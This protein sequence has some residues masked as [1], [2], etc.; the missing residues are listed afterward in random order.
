MD[1][2]LQNL[3]R[4]Y[5]SKFSL[6]ALHHTVMETLKANWANDTLIILGLPL[7]S[8]SQ[9]KISLADVVRES[10][11]KSS[12]GFRGMLST[13]FAFQF[14]YARAWFY[15]TDHWL[16]LSLTDP[17]DSMAFS[18]LDAFWCLNSFLKL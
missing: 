2:N 9:I 17:P 16:C 10:F 3:V 5:F 1:I 15:W 7:K 18:R 12:P 11:G 4:G 6:R 14:V 8:A 13:Y